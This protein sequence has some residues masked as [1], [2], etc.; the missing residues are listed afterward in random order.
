[1]IVSGL[2]TRARGRDR[3]GCL[4]N[5]VSGKFAVSEK[6]FGSQKNCH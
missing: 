4:G 3:R 6:G 1:M 5:L 2:R